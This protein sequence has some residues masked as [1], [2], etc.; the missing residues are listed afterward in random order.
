[1]SDPRL[2]AQAGAL[3]KRLGWRICTAE[4]CTGGLIAHRL[5]NIPGSSAYMLGGIVAYANDVKQS[6]LD[7]PEETLIAFGAVSA[8]TAEAMVRGALARFDADAAVAVTGIAGPD[9]GTPEKPVGL[10]YIGALTR[11]GALRIERHIWQGDREAV[12]QQS[13]DAALRLIIA[14]ADGEAQ[15]LA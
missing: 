15:G 11:S 4:S 6:L 8:Q 12:K 10:T 14:L 2:E 7:V 1:M 9:G 5:T 13:A 3:L